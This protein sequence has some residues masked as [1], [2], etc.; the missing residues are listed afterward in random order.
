MFTVRQNVIFILDNNITLQGHIQN[1]GSMVNVEGGIFKMKNGATITGN[2][3]NSYSSG[4]GGVYVYGGT[5]EMEG[6][7]I[8]GNTASSGGGVYVSSGTF[9]M[10][11]G[12]ISGNTASNGGGVYNFDTFTMSGGTISGNK[13]NKNGGGVYASWAQTIIQGGN[14]TNNNAA[15]YGGGL[16]YGGFGFGRYFSKIGG[17]ITG[18]NSDPNNGNVVKDASGVLAR[19]GHAVYVSETKHKET[20]AGPNVNLYNDDPMNWDD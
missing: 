1:T 7:T 8:S 13:A 6:G 18:Y 14:I 15:E 9:T 20:T 17:T 19:R 2:T 4:G 3:D 12:T 5:F 16:Y 10:S 11:G